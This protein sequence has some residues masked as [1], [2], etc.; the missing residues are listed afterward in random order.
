LYKASLDDKKDK[1][2]IS[3]IPLHFGLTTEE[4][5]KITDISESNTA[6]FLDYIKG[7]LRNEYDVGVTEES[8]ENFVESAS[9]DSNLYLFPEVLRK[10]FY[11]KVLS[12]LKP[13]YTLNEE[14]SN[15]KKEEVL[16]EIEP[17]YKKI[18]KGEAI[19][20]KYEEITEE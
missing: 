14:E 17:I 13:N 2:K 12:S 15:K 19:V 18:I 7:K 10:D 11:F 3:D 9:K 5:K 20:R 4:M 16:N 8:L 1:M 6:S